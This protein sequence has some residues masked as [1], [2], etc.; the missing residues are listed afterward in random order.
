MPRQES[1]LCTRL[2]KRRGRGRRTSIR[3][4]ALYLGIGG[5]VQYVRS[6]RSRAAN[7]FLVLHTA[8]DIL[9]VMVA[10]RPLKLADGDA[11]RR[12]RTQFCIAEDAEAFG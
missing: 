3:L 9:W 10:S 11:C 4:K 2:R 8:V 1:N 12:D 6:G 7:H 5:I